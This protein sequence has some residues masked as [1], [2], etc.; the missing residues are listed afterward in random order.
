VD[1]ARV[2]R[3]DSWQHRWFFDESYFNLYRHSKRYWVRAETDDAFSMPKLTEAQEKVSVGIA[4]AIRHGRKSALAFLPKG[5]SGPHLVD[6]WKKALL[7]SLRWQSAGRDRN[8]L[9][10]D[11]DGRH[12]IGRLEGLR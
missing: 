7:P 5:W 1:F 6:A 4:V 10:I 3:H 8:E 12:S 2:H 9:V 11:N